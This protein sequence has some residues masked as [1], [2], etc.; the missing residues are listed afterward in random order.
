LLLELFWQN[1]Y[2]LF[3]WMKNPEDKVNPERGAE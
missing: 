1:S 3:H 2:E